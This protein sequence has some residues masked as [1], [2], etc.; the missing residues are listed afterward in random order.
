MS[1]RGGGE[2][3]YLVVCLD[4]ELNLLAGESA[5]SVA[6]VSPHALSSRMPRSTSARRT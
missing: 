5:Y 6:C 2:A 3:A 4:V 1:R